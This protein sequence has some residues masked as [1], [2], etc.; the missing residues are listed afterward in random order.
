[1]EIVIS[2]EEAQIEK[3]DAEEAGP[4]EPPRP[5]KKNIDELKLPDKKMRKRCYLCPF[6]LFA[7]RTRRLS[8]ITGHNPLV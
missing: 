2:R 4:T 7:C 1:L 8:A 3:K 5:E 6:I